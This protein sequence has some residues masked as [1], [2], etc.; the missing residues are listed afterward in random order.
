MELSPKLAELTPKAMEITPQALE[1]VT[2]RSERLNNR[3]ANA[4][5]TVINRTVPYGFLTSLKTDNDCRH[6]YYFLD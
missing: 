4:Y 3:A 5:D 2:G 1:I 6:P